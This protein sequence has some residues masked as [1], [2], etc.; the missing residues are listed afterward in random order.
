MLSFTSNFFWPTNAPVQMLA[1][2]IPQ[3]LLPHLLQ[4]SYSKSPWVWVWVYSSAFSFYIFFLPP[5]RPLEN[6]YYDLPCIIIKKDDSS[7]FVVYRLFLTQLFFQSCTITTSQDDGKALWAPLPIA[8]GGVLFVI[9]V[10]FA[11][12]AWLLPHR[13]GRTTTKGDISLMIKTAEST[14]VETFFV[15]PTWEGGLQ[16]FWKIHRQYQKILPQITK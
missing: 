4:V 2:W 12:F 3:Q 5:H 1:E 11:I 14:K 13:I 6:R 10:I 8:V 7:W 9:L 16:I 15:T